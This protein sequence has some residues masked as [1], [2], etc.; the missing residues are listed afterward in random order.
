MDLCKEIAS[1]LQ[2][3]FECT[4]LDGRIRVRTPFVYPDG[5]V[6]DVFIKPQGD[7]V[8]ITDLGETVRWLRSVTL[9]A[10]RSPKQQRLLHEVC[11]THNVAFERG[12]LKVTSTQESVAD[13]LVRLSQAALSVSDLWFTF[14]SRTVSSAAD[15]VSDFFEEREISFHRSPKVVGVSGREH[16][17]DFSTQTPGS[18]KLLCLLSTGSRASVKGLVE[19]VVAT[20]YDLREW[21]LTEG[22]GLISLFDDTIDIWS[23]EDFKQLDGLSSIARWSQQDAFEELVR[24]A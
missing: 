7:S 24:A 21:P 12:I 18:E 23:P 6:L 2:G 9:S 13:A 20:F 14:R 16:R 19:H 22:R 4:D 15:D 10:K 17:L 11:K 1:K 5:D 8:T 3:S